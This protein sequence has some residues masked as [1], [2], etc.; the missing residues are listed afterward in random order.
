VAALDG[1]TCSVEMVARAA[2]S[3][4]F[5][6]LSD[7]CAREGGMSPGMGSQ[8]ISAHHLGVVG[9]MAAMPAEISG[10]LLGS[11][12]GRRGGLPI[13]LLKRWS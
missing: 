8:C 4:L 5:G 9:V 3:D 10:L 1:E 11:G 6:D 2:V 12:G 7:R 13:C